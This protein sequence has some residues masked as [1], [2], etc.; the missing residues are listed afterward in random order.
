MPSHSEIRGAPAGPVW[1]LDLDL[2]GRVY[3]VADVRVEV[4]G[5]L[6]EPGLTVPDVALSE[7]VGEIG[8]SIDIGEDWAALDAAGI[9]VAFAGAV[10]RR[11]WPGQPLERAQVIIA[12]EAVDPEFGDRDEELTISIVR[13]ELSGLLLDP[14]A[15]VDGITWPDHHAGANLTRAPAAEGQWY[16]LPIG[17]PG[18]TVL[19]VGVVTRPATP[20]LLVAARWSAADP[21]ELEAGSL[22]LIAD[23]PVEA[24]EV[25]VYYEDTTG[26]QRQEVVDVLTT[27]DALGRVVSVIDAGALSHP[28]GE[29][30]ELWIGW[31]DADGRGGILEGPGGT[32]L[33]G[34]GDVIVWVLRDRTDLRVDWARLDAVRGWLNGFRVD[35]VVHAEIDAWEWVR[36]ELLRLLPVVEAESAEGLYL[37]RVRWDATAQDAVAR[38]DADAGDID[39]ETRLVALDQE[40]WNE[41]ELVY[42]LARG[43]A[44]I[45]RLW[46]SGQPGRLSDGPEDARVLFHVASAASQGRPAIGVRRR[47]EPILGSWIYDDATGALVLLGLADR[48][49]IQVS[50]VRYSGGWDLEVLEEWDAVLIQDSRVSLHDRVALVARRTL[51]QDRVLLDLYVLPARVGLPRATGTVERWPDPA[52]AAGLPQDPPSEGIAGGEYGL[53]TGGY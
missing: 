38:L 16:P 50:A 3:R 5:H 14:A 46:V 45:S 17:M 8:V 4:D 44:W 51:E 36:A 9:G 25:R 23:R 19:T 20:A 33:R 18:R 48:H 28:I 2:D 13:P 11:L 40:A 21:P 41:A 53:P 1:L 49:A 6:Y 7:R 15:R 43:E 26:R 22:A 30:P 34:A 42:G 29:D 47:G 52:L 12:G 31:G 24:D 39:R 27:T 32:L 37:R 10:L 35:T